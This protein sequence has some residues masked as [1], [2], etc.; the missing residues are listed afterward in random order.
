MAPIKFEE[1]IKLALEKR[2]IGPSKSAWETLEKSLDKDLGKSKK[3][4]FWWMGVAASIIG[5][6][7]FSISFFESNNEVIEPTIVEVQNDNIE[8]PT[9]VIS[10]QKSDKIVKEDVKLNKPTVTVN[11]ELVVVEK[12]SKKVKKGKYL[13]LEKPQNRN[14]EKQTLIA[15]SEVETPEKISEE[16]KQLQEVAAQVAALEKEKATE[17]E[18]DDLL[19]NAQQKV[20]NQKF[21]ES[22]MSVSAYS[23]LA[24]VEEEIDPSFRDKVFKVVSENYHSIKNAVAQRND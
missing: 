23:L 7:W 17:E 4:S 21:K 13:E 3:K 10:N 2:R 16:E 8:T 1:D 12:P 14:I 20:R 15:K 22:E 24:E 5:I 11:Q 6:L 9:E 18:I 19:R